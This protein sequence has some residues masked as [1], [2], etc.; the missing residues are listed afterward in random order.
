MSF[1]PLVVFWEY[2]FVVNYKYF[3]IQDERVRA[4]RGYSPNCYKDKDAIVV[5]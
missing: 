1:D 2:F 5:M 4:S 3:L